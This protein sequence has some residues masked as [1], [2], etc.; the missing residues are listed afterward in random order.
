MT[1]ITV[2]SHLLLSAYNGPTENSYDVQG[3]LA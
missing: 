1:V 3:H 2:M